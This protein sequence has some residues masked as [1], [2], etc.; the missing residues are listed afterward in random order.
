[1]NTG[2]KPK[3]AVT[4]ITPQRKRVEIW[5]EVKDPDLLAA[6]IKS[7]GS[8]REASTAIGWKSHTFLQRLMRGEV[9]TLS[10]DSALLLA[11]YLQVHPD[12]LFLTKVSTEHERTGDEKCSTFSGKKKAS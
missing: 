12:V 6:L 9:K 3:V 11:R 5:M 7:K 10:T 4:V 8:T 1:M 2:H